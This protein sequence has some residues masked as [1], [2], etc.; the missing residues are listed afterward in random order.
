MAP[1]KTINNNICKLSSL[2]A[3]GFYTGSPSYRVHSGTS[4][5]NKMLNSM[6]SIVFGIKE[7]SL[8]SLRKSCDKA[9][10][11]ETAVHKQKLFF[12][13]NSS[14]KFVNFVYRAGLIF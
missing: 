3:A 2:V 1:I 5:L 8:W 7:Q 14:F 9:I 12:S 13:L 11:I 4:F 10:L 6:T